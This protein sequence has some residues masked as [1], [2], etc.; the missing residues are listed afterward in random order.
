MKMSAVLRS[1]QSEL[2]QV[3]KEKVCSNFTRQIKPALDKFY[4]DMMNCASATGELAPTKVD[5]ILYI[6]SM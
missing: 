5:I 6:L 3:G 4:T 2:E 1:Y